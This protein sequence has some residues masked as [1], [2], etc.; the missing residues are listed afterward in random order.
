MKRSLLHFPH[1][2][3]KHTCKRTYL[4]PFHEKERK[5][6]IRVENSQ[7]ISQSVLVLFFFL[8][9]ISKYKKTL[10]V[11]LTAGR[12]IN[13]YFN[14]FSFTIF[15]TY[16]TQISQFSDLFLAVLKLF[17]RIFQLLH[18]FYV[19]LHNTATYFGNLSFLIKKNSRHTATCQQ[20]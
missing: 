1:G 9:P 6:Q 14:S 18:F 2:N 10:S 12:P 15:C 19:S 13:V 11:F 5:C 8:K 4:G 17:G 20:A 7:N 16:S 3:T